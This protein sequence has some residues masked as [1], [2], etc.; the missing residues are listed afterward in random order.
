[1][2]ENISLVLWLSDKI[3][4]QYDFHKTLLDINPL[5]DSRV[6]S[7]SSI[8]NHSP[9]IVPFVLTDVGFPIS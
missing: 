2:S 6:M 3:I 7:T 4:L 8:L 9:S 5:S 1:M